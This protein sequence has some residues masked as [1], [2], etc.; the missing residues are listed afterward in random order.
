MSFEDLAQQHEAMELAQINA[1]RSPQPTY[2]PSEPGYGPEECEDCGAEMH[3]VRR[4]YGFTLCT[5]CKSAR[6]PR[7][8]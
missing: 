8:R 3:P 6:G 4:A 1:P 5:A 7:R 2:K